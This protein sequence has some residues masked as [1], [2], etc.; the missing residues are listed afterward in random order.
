MSNAFK[1]ES[2]H[3]IGLL[4]YFT[5]SDKRRWALVLEFGAR[6]GC[7]GRCWKCGWCWDWGCAGDGN[8]LMMED[9]RWGVV[10]IDW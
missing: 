3:C 4:S 9:W 10:E 5:L 7:G 8:G 1:F 2:M 6:V